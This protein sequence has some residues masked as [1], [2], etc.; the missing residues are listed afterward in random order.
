[1]NVNSVTKNINNE[2][3]NRIAYFRQITKKN[4]QEKKNNE[5]KIQRVLFLFPFFF[6]ASYIDK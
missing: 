1:M 2:T 6:H 5:T 4:N 3:R